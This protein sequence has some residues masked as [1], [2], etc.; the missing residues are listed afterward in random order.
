VCSS[1]HTG[2]D[3]ETGCAFDGLDQR[4]SEGTLP[5]PQTDALPRGV[6]HS[7]W[8]AD[9]PDDHADSYS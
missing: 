8:S 5:P 6:L 3:A 4:I 2:L 7:R 1:I 9:E